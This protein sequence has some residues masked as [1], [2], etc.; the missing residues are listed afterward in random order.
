MDKIESNVVAELF[1]KNREDALLVGSIKSNVGQTE[2]AAGF[3]SVLKAVFALDLGTLA[4]N[5]HVRKINKGIQAFSQNQ[6]QV[7]PLSN[8]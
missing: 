3:M 6:L 5:N 4:P 2:A 1:S 7:I 8:K